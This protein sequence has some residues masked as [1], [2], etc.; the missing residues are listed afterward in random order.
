MSVPD[1]L[2]LIHCLLVVFYGYQI[3]KFFFRQFKYSKIIN[4]F[5]E[6]QTS[7]IF[8]QAFQQSGVAIIFNF[9]LIHNFAWGV[10]LREV[11]IEFVV[12]SIFSFLAIILNERVSAI[13]EEIEVMEA[14]AKA[15]AEFDAAFRDIDDEEEF[16]GTRADDDAA[17][18]DDDF[19][20]RQQGS[21][22]GNEKSSG[23]RYNKAQAEADQK[24]DYEA[25]MAW[26]INEANKV[27]NELAEA[28]ARRMDRKAAK[29]GLHPR[30]VMQFSILASLL[31]ERVKGWKGKAKPASDE[32]IDQLLLEGK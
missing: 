8:E 18:E 5:V 3:G 11:P 26:A 28:A 21:E 1:F 25:A 20:N 15:Q 6:T 19:T 10:Y 27:S 9:L 31:R 23:P 14:K 30:D 13:F 12:F 7:S 32:E 4:A 2:Y 17:F 22:S 24:A 29:P 16:A